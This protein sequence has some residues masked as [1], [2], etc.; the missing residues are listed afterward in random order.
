M[1]ILAPLGLGVEGLNFMQMEQR[2][3]IVTYLSRGKNVAG[4]TLIPAQKRL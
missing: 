3:V 4:I 1:Y 2:A